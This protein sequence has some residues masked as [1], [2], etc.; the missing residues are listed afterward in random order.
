MKRSEIG[1][2]KGLNE[3][4]TSGWENIKTKNKVLKYWNEDGKKI[5][6]RMEENIAKEYVKW[7]A[8]NWADT[9]K[10]I[11]LSS[12][13]TRLSK[14]RCTKYYIVPPIPWTL[15]NCNNK[16]KSSQAGISIPH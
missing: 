4:R 13:T 10:W 12:F 14:Y 15:Y 7:L 6:G 5:K 16:T 8:W 2:K 9:R 1:E 11:D 3:N